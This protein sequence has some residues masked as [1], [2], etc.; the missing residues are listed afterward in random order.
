MFGR[1]G[2]T[3][4]ASFYSLRFGP[5][6]EIHGHDD[7]LGITY[8]ARGRDLI[9]DAGHYGYTATPYRAW[10][11]SP[12]AAST[13]VLP[14]VPFSAAAATSL[15]ADRIGPYGQF[16][17]L[18]DTA[19]GGDPRYRSVYVSQR[20]D[21]VIVFDRAAGRIGR[22]QPT[23]SS[24]TWTRPCT[25][26]ASRASTA[27]AT[28]PGTSLTLAQVALPGQVIPAG[29]TQVVVGQTDPYQGWVSHQ[30]LQQI[31]ADV[32]T[33]TR[34][35]PSAAHPHAAR[36]HR[37]RHAGGLLGHRPARQVLTGSASRSA[38]P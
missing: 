33:M 5:G 17:E 10:L 23:R 2:W 6:R 7:H 26:P 36:P 25:S 14:G 3:S 9:V 32:V 37:S 11:Q 13:L 38:R 28:A 4:A 12:E 19:F 8:Y 35:G 1:S 30:M 24:G 29:S 20:P 34:T 21:L 22:D 16:Y 31:P 15:V 18:Y 27:V